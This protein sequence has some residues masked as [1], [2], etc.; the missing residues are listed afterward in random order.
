MKNQLIVIT[1]ASSGIGAEMARLLSAEGAFVVLAAR[2][3]D[4]LK[5]VAEGLPGKCGIVKL[6]VSSEESVEQAFREIADRYGPVDCLI[7]NAGFGYFK[8][9]DQLEIGDFEEM[10]NVNFTGAVRCT[11]MVLP[12]MV[13]AGHGQIVNIAS[14]A[15]KLGTAKST[16][17]SASKHAL[18]GF[19]NSLRQELKGTGVTISA[20]NPG[21]I[22]TPF[23]E[24]ADPEGSYVKNVG[25]F[26]M[27]PEK[28]AKT[29]VK[30]I[31]RKQ[32]EA[33]L[34]FP[35]AFGTKLYQLFPRIAD[36]V[37]GRFINN[38]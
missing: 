4:K 25:W 18:L 10:M 3:E 7:N 29:V 19:T 1:G 35:A 36:K 23:F 11:K 24:V 17:Y 30:V 20:V 14:I 32:T 6:D 33:D 21:P 28:V 12:A 16:A 5:A 37:S 9:F 8:P 31:R 38:K 15:G 27:E 22:R 34:P 13:K 26:M 2:S